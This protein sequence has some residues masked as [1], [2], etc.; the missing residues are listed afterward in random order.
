[1]G[2][3][4]TWLHPDGMR[5]DYVHVLPDCV[6]EARRRE[7]VAHG[8]NELLAPGGR[9]LASAYIRGTAH[10]RTSAQLLS[11]LGY[12]VVGESRPPVG[13]PRTPPS[14]AWIDAP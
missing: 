4:A 6:P 7:L 1:V 3:A 11:G 13:D 5:F 2:D 12:E 10:D 9:L 8:L 14:T